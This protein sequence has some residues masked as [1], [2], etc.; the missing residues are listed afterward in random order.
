MVTS[1]NFAASIAGYGLQV[2]RAFEAI[3]KLNFV[4]M[5]ITVLL[6]WWAIPRFGIRGA[7]MAQGLGEGL[8][9]AILWT[10]FLKAVNRP[11]QTGG[12]K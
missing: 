7:L 10:K 12:E 3:A 8:L 1:L 5:I 6:A 2:T 4:T 9:A 11:A